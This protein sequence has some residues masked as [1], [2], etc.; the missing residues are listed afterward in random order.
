MRPIHISLCVIMIVAAAMPLAGCTSETAVEPAAETT[1][2]PPPEPTH[3]IVYIEEQWT[4]PA[5]DD[6]D[7][8]ARGIDWR[9]S[10]IDLATGEESVLLADTATMASPPVGLLLSPDGTQLLYGE[11]VQR[12]SGVLVRYAGWA[13][14]LHRVDLATETDEVVLPFVRSFGWDGAD[15][16]ATTWRD[17]ISVIDG[18]GAIAYSSPPPNGVVRVSGSEVTTLVPDAPALPAEPDATMLTQQLA[19]LGS[20]GGD[21]YFDEPQLVPH[22]GPLQAPLHIWRLRSGETSLTPAITLTSG[23]VAVGP[24][25]GGPWERRPDWAYEADMARFLGNGLFPTQ[26]WYARLVTYPGGGSSP[27]ET[28]ESVIVRRAS[29]MKVVASIEITP[30]V[31]FQYRVGRAFDAQITR[32]LEARTLAPPEVPQAGTWLC[33]TEFDSGRMTPIANMSRDASA[34][35]LMGYVGTDLDALYVSEKPTAPELASPRRVF[36][37]ERSTGES[38][39]L[40]EFV[41]AHDYANTQVELVGDAALEMAR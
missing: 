18:A 19:Y 11:P 36:M 28:S 27:E 37:W 14:E 1:T 29:D 4:E 22:W 33:E 40:V 38:R 5:S 12:P 41:A 26:Q 15:I 7:S 10:G 31:P 8:D 34:T 6:S 23:N 16:I 25:G 9:I 35:A 17:W 24:E 2:T 30:T 21:L 39:L 32:W 13:L 3:A 20:D